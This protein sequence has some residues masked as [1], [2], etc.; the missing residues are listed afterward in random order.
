MSDND[1]TMNKK[2]SMKSKLTVITKP[3]TNVEG[4]LNFLEA[5]EAMKRKPKRWNTLK[6]SDL[7]GVSE[8]H[9]FCGLPPL[10]MASH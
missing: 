1:K 9:V 10:L 2:K 4:Y 8:Q 7:K 5:N 3:F 6:K